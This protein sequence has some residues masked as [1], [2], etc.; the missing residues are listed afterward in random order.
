[1]DA[2]D[3]AKLRPQRAIALVIFA[4]LA[5]AVIVFAITLLRVDVATDA[6]HTTQLERVGL[7]RISLLWRILGA[8]TDYRRSLNEGASRA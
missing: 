4:A 2:Q 5:I 7:T 6:I 3:Q 8:A 1:M